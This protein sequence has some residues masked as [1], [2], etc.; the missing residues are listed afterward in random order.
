MH[1][2]RVFSAGYALRWQNDVSFIDNNTFYIY[3]G[4]SLST[5][6]FFFS[7][8]KVKEKKIQNDSMI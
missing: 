7:V 1:I 4:I 3:T 2:M 5:L 8:L 6:N